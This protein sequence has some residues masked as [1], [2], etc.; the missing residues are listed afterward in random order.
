MSS[1]RFV[2]RW[3]SCCIVVLLL[4]AFGCTDLPSPVPR[5]N[6]RPE[7]RLAIAPVHTPQPSQVHI[8]W[9]GDDPDGFVT[10]FLFSWDQRHWYFTRKSDSVFQLRIHRQ[11][12]LFTF[13]IAAVDNSVSA[14]PP[15]DTLVP[16]PFD[17]RNQNQKRDEDEE[18]LGLEGGVDLTPAS[19]QYFVKNTPPRIYW[20]PDSTAAAAALMD[21]PDT[22]FPVVTFVFSAYDFDGQETL[23]A[24]EWALNDTTGN[25]RWHRIPANQTLLTLHQE[26]GL[27]LNAPN[28]FFV[29]AVDIGGLRSRTLQYPD[30]GQQWYVKNPSG[31][32]LVI[33]DS[34]D[35]RA[36]EF[37]RTALNTIANGR[38]AGRYEWMN[39]REKVNGWPR[40]LPRILN[41][42][43]QQ[44][45]Q[46]FDLV[47]WYG[48]IGLSV[49]FPQQVLPEF[50]AAGG[51]VIFSA[52]LP[53]FATEEEA[54]QILDF[55]PLDSISL[56]ELF[57]S[58]TVFRPGDTLM[59]AAEAVAEFPV[60]EKGTGNV[61]GVHRLYP[62]AT[63]QPLYLLP[64]RQEYAG[65]PVVGLHSRIQG[66]FFF[67]FPL[68]AF[69]RNNGAVQLL[70]R[71]IVEKFQIP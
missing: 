3:N 48:D 10:G 2:K 64:P 26:D 49:F 55:A 38:Y 71:I 45:L 54:Q 43:F 7:T 8:Y 32:I 59:R 20:G 66:N 4:F 46:L 23:E 47:L 5:E 69:N 15:A 29:R 18:F 51:K 52:S 33:E 16:V 28:T 11:D 31:P 21:L 53:N 40:S 14:L 1:Q 24:I 25:A 61:V 63:A 34:E 58:P 13:W 22:T 12:S 37:Y 30:S 19:T 44:T 67:N 9:Y 17:D 41:P 50:L 27:L 57:S 70:E 6:L 65:T 42:M 39:I 60:L 62:S 35:L 68:H 56:K 36:R